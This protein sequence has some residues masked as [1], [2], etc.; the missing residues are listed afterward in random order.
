ML[1]LWQ[2]PLTES[3]ADP[4]V[5]RPWDPHCGSALCS[6]ILDMKSNHL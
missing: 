4:R 3:D 2:S 5:T 1:I 6:P